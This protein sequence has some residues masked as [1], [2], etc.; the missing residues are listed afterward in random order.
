MAEFS[1]ST[2]LR[3][4]M[5]FHG[6]GDLVEAEHLYRSI[7]ST[8]RDYPA[9]LHLLGVIEFQRGR[10]ENAVHLIDEALAIKPDYVEA[11]VDRANILCAQERLQEALANYDQALSLKPHNPNGLYNRGCVLQRLNRQK[12]ALANYDQALAIKPSFAEALNNRGNALFALGRIQEALASYDL[13]LAIKPDDVDALSSRGSALSALGCLEEALECLDRALSIKPGYIDALYNRGNALRRMN[14]WQAAQESYSRVLAIK[15]D[16]GAAKFALCMAELPILYTDE[17]EVA[18]QRTAYQRRLTALCD[19]VIG[20]TAIG[21]LAKA[22]GLHQ[23]FYLAYQGQDDR[24]LQIKYGSLVCRIMAARYPPTALPVPP[25]PDEPVRVGIVSGFFKLHSNWKLHT[26][27]TLSE[28]DRRCFRVFGYHTGGEVDS[29]TDIAVAACDRFVQGPLSIGEWR[30]TILTDA[31]H[32][33]IYPEIGMNPAAA[34]LAAQRLAPVQCSRFGH[35]VTSGFPTLDYFLSSDLMEPPN[36][37]QHYTERLIRLPNLSVYYEPFDVPPLA[38]TRSELGL[39]STAIVYWCGQS[40]F[41]YLPQYDSMF[42]RIARDAGDCQFAFIQHSKGTLVTELFKQRL[43]RAFASVG[44]RAGDHCVFLPRLDFPQFIATFA[45]CDVM[46]DSI[47]WSGNNTTMESFAHALPIVTMTGPLMRGRHTMAILK[48]M[49]I[50][51]TITETV[52]EYCS[53]AVRLAR[54]VPWR[55]AI[56]ARMEANKNKVYRDKASILA[57]EEFLKRAVRQP[58]P[59]LIKLE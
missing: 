51:E 59:G 28:L 4:A 23:P 57:L 2:V 16:H 49:G 15:S 1:L 42:A 52:D 34:A 26:K 41:K 47:G 58:P 3:Q 35:P 19:D 14:R 39:R 44:L 18:R 13:A 11:L 25:G 10:P 33:L 7:L 20:S 30:Q 8:K 50:T 37:Q 12:D 36:G 38:L 31:P 24:D 22:V 27:G 48:M 17:A 29:E 6:A 9:A 45:Q 5:A 21:D 40:L 46:L 54:D 55:M 43:E 53:V 56:K 32:V